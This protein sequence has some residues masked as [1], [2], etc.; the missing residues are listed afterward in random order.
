MG[1]VQT[2]K[3][4]VQG[5]KRNLAMLRQ[6]TQKEAVRMFGA[7]LLIDLINQR[8]GTKGILVG[9]VVADTALN[10]DQIWRKIPS[11]FPTGNGIAYKTAGTKLGQEIIFAPENQLVITP[12]PKEYQSLTD[13]ALVMRQASSSDIL[14]DGN[15]TLFE[16]ALANLPSPL[17]T[18]NIDALADAVNQ[19]VDS[20]REFR[21]NT[22]KFVQEQR[23]K[24]V[25]GYPA[26]SG[27]R[28][29]VDRETGVPFGP[30][31][32]GKDTRLNYRNNGDYAGLLVRDVDGVNRRDVY[33]DFRP[34]GGFGVVTEISEGDAAKIEAL[35]SLGTVPQ[36]AKK[37]EEKAVIVVP[38]I[39][40][41]RLSELYQGATGAV[42]K[43]G[44]VVD[45]QLLTPLK[46]FLAAI[47]KAK[48]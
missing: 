44:N 14:V 12:V 43:M 35:F 40:I 1:S 37:T 8:F 45:A 9:N 6:N 18:M 32:S 25:S 47:G 41:A 30:Q 39:S 16:Y 19:I 23:L 15:K 2:A 28:H 31:K 46:E 36:T 24:A 27:T 3:V 20:V 42:E 13:A 10:V 5:Q 48:F 21:F 33:A 26:T 22:P 11:A 7:L 17:E 4:S 34:S 29:E 38:G